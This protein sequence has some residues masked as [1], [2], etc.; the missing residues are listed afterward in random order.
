MSPKLPTLNSTDVIRILEK[1]GFRFI[2]QRGSHKMFLK[3]SVGVVVPFHR[4]DLRKGTL[5]Q[6]IKQSGIPIED[7]IKWCSTLDPV[8]KRGSATRSLSAGHVVRERR[9]GMTM[10]EYW[11][12]FY[13]NIVALVKRPFETRRYVLKRHSRPSASHP[14]EGFRNETRGEQI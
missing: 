5:H 2:R 13:Y 3:G 8:F 12:I 1:A 7:F 6:I 10:L 11:S 14:L 4:K 9:V